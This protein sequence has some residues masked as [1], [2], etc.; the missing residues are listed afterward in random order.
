MLKNDLSKIVKI[1]AFLKDNLH[2]LKQQYLVI[3]YKSLCK[4]EQ[5]EEIH[6]KLYKATIN[7][8]KEFGF[9][10]KAMYRKAIILTNQLKKEVSY[11]PMDLLSISVFAALNSLKV[12]NKLSK[13]ITK[14]TDKIEG[15]MKVGAL[16]D[17]LS[18]NIEKTKE[19]SKKEDIDLDNLKIFY[20]ASWHQDSAKDHK[21][22]QGKI[23]V[24]ENWEKV[25]LPFQ[26]KNAIRYYIKSHRVKTMQ[27]VI[28]SPVWFITRPNCRHY[29]KNVSVKEVL[30][31]SSKDL[32]KKYDLS[33]AIGNR[34]Y[35]QTL[36]H[37]DADKLRNAELMLEAY[38]RRLKLHQ[39]LYKA[40]PNN[41]IKSA[42]VKDKML[43][44]KWQKYY[45]SL[46]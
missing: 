30:D 5:I 25:N 3:I 18:T 31:S 38:K 42:I 24:D 29:F 40:N 44:S 19:E 4:R 7:F 8:K 13:Q 9:E 28:G 22:Y 6:K 17:E 12:E 36:K 14:Y 20:L 43:I 46:N 34:Q 15:E 1:K 45:D 33:T 16:A 41:L 35:L 23:Y 32:I 2:N 11:M 27:W 10:N 26:I 21:D 37:K 39:E